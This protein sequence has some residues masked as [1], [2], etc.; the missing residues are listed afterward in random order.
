MLCNVIARTG[1]CQTTWSSLDRWSSRRVA[2]HSSTPIQ[3][4]SSERQSCTIRVARVV[5]RR[6]EQG[7]DSLS[8]AAA[9]FDR[10]VLAVVP[11]KRRERL[12][13]ALG[14]RGP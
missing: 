3:M 2:Q 8:D 1:T 11:A 10:R 4:G 12:S 6:L 7:G 9:S 13:K 14:P 5:D